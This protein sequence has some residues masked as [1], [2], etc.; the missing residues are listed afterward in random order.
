[1]SKNA[2][3]K[4]ALSESRPLRPSQGVVVLAAVIVWFLLLIYDI[5]GQN[6]DAPITQPEILRILLPI[7]GA[8]PAAIRFWQLRLDDNDGAAYK[9]FRTLTLTSAVAA[10]VLSI[11]SAIPFSFSVIGVP[12]TIWSFIAGR[13]TVLAWMVMVPLILEPLVLMFSYRSHERRRAAPKVFVS[14]IMLALA[15]AQVFPLDVVDDHAQPDRFLL[16]IA[17]C[18]SLLGLVFATRNGWIINLRK[19]QKWRVAGYA[20]LGFFAAVVMMIALQHSEDAAAAIISFSPG[21]S[22]QVLVLH[23]TLLFVCAVVFVSVIVA[24]PTAGAIDRRNAEVSSLTNLSRLL[25]ESLDTDYVIDT[26][27]TIAC[28]AIGSRVAWIELREADEIQIRLGQKPRLSLRMAKML[29]TQQASRDFVIAEAVSQHRQPVAVD[30]LRNISLYR[31]ESP[32]EMRSVAAAPLLVGEKLLGAIYVAKNDAG[33]FDRRN[34]LLLN[35]LANQIAFA[36]EQSR[37]MRTSLERERF[38]QE[39]LIARDLQERLL[40][41]QMPI[42][43]FYELYAESLPASIVGG[44]YFDVVAFSDNTLGVLVA[45]VSGKGASAAL[46]MGMIKGI[47]QAISGQCAS[48]KELLARTNV[49]LHGIID[50]RWFA[51]MVCAQIIDERRTLRVAR[52]GHCPTLA[53]CNGKA[54]YSK[55][56]GLGLAIARP[57]LFDQHLAVEEMVFGPGDYAIFFS[58]GLPE[59]R[60][61]DGEEWGYERLLESVADAGARGLNPQQMRDA[62]YDRIGGFSQGEPLADDSTLLILRW[63]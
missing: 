60:S 29:M 4:P 30:R 19:E 10:V 33:G 21:L 61:P 59:A 9:A 40:P 48:P 6:W 35:A 63:H 20:S 49:A 31:G 42:S 27:I 2:N 26:A 38:E 3:D 1:M 39:M 32:G 50:Q 46:Y 57:A 47:V 45:D 14:C 58:D 24:L 54:A 52:A 18:V 28:D 25:T 5:I 11:L 56:P 43:P 36:I 17:G 55:P 37:L 16:V 53:V 34:L 22:E 13:I 44:D 23:L 8:I 51:T 62:I 12:V 7:L 15:L 41:K